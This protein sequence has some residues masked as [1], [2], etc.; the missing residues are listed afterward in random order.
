VLPD[1]IANGQ[2]NPHADQESKNL[3]ENE[4]QKLG[5]HRKP[6]K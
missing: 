3:G 4:K 1:G 5:R 6:F 2:D